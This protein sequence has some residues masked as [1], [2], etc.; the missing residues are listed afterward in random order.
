MSVRAKFRVN[1][2]EDYGS[3]KKIKLNAVY[4]GQL[5]T[6]EENKRF[7]KATPNGEFWMTVDN[8][9]AS[10]QFKVGQEWYLN[11]ELAQDVT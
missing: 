4:E 2:I 3:S 5:G 6:N 8:P 10:N 11:C 1:V 7:S 9:F